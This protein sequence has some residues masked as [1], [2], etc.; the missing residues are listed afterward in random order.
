MSEINIDVT[1]KSKI[2]YGLGVL[3]SALYG[4]LGG[5]TKVA[6]AI[7]EIAEE[8]PKN[9]VT[10]GE[11]LSLVTVAGIGVATY[12]LAKLAGYFYK[13]CQ[14]P[15]EEASWLFQRLQ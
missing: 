8:V 12:G 10:T 7:N 2:P 15:N 3:A 5:F 14:K 13:E 1:P 4:T 9:D 11:L 6:S